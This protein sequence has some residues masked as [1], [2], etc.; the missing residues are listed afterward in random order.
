MFL[1]H[2]D[3]SLV[4]HTVLLKEEGIVWWNCDC[5]SAA[6]KHDGCHWSTASPP[7]S[8]DVDTSQSGR[9]VF[10][11]DIEDLDFAGTATLLTGAGAAPETIEASADYFDRY[12]DALWITST[13]VSG[14]AEDRSVT[15]EG[16]A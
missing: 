7:Q 10:S 13:A 8:L 2:P 1:F 12:P 9:F 16:T 15:E 5:S 14:L 11:V 4:S 3:A 6:T